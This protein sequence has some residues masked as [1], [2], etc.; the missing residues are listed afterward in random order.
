[1]HN[2]NI[3][4]ERLKKMLEV[5]D[6]V[7]EQIKQIE[8]IKKSIDFIIESIIEFMP[9]HLQQMQK[10]IREQSQ[11]TKD[12]ESIIEFATGQMQQIEKDIKEQMQQVKKS[13]ESITGPVIIQL[14]KTISEGLE[15]YNKPIAKNKQ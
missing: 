11:T 8:Q 2:F 14:E 9:G 7:I 15:N 3:I 1:M 10:T 4:N 12:I 6:K 13:I 5:S